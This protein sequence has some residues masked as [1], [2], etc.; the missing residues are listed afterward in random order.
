MNVCEIS[1]VKMFIIYIYENAF[2]VLMNKSNK[3]LFKEKMVSY[4]MGRPV[5]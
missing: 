3:K 2:M 1:G 4:I 5:Q